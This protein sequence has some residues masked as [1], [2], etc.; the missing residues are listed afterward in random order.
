MDRSITRDF[1][2]EP[3]SKDE[4]RVAKWLSDKGLGGG[5]D[6]IGFIITSYEMNM[7]LLR[8]HREALKDYREVNEET[9]FLGL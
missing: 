2:K 6:P 4:E 1:E 9:K 5:D 8:D 7:R 3:Y